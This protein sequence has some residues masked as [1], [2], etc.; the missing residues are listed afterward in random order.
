[1][2]GLSPKVESGPKAELGMPKLVKVK[3]E[4]GAEKR[5]RVKMRSA[6]EGAAPLRPI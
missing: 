6:E 1:L 3:P 2:S 4:R 5:A